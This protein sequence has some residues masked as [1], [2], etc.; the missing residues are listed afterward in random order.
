LREAP[1]APDPPEAPYIYEIKNSKARAFVGLRG[2]SIPEVARQS[3]STQ[4]LPEP[5]PS[6]ALDYAA[7]SQKL[8]T[9]HSAGDFVFEILRLANYSSKFFVVWGFLNIWKNIRPGQ[10]SKSEYTIQTRIFEGSR[11]FP[12]K[13]FRNLFGNLGIRFPFGDSEPRGPRAAKERSHRKRLLSPK[14]NDV[15]GIEKFFPILQT[16]IENFKA[17]NS[18]W[19]ASRQSNEYA[20]SLTGGYC[21]E[22]DLRGTSEVALCDNGFA[23]R[24]EPPRR[25]F[26]IL[27]TSHLARGAK[28]SKSASRPALPLASACVYPKGYLFIGPPGTGKTLLARALAGEVG[29]RLIALSASEIQKQIDVGTRI[30]AIRLRNLFQF[31]KEN[32]PCILFFDEIDSIGK[33]HDI[34]LFTE[35]LIQMDGLGPRKLSWKKFRA[36]K[37]SLTSWYCG[38]ADCSEADCGEADLWGTSSTPRFLKGNPIIPNSP[39]KQEI[40]VIG[41]TN[42]FT[43]LDSAFIRSGRFDRII[44]LQ[45]PGK[46][47]RISIL[48]L[49]CGACGKAEESPEPGSP[50]RK[51]LLEASI[52]ESDW[53]FFGDITNGLSAADLSRIVNESL[54]FLIDEEERAGLSGRGALPQDPLRSGR[55]VSTQNS[56]NQFPII[57]NYKRPSSSGGILLHTNESIKKG[58]EKILSRERFIMN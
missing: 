36:A 23:P 27:G 35:F 48:K 6:E 25:G 19:S 58:I 20:E 4:T 42:N 39:Q 43:N 31:A 14:L 34:T 15:E 37:P 13:R 2:E 8:F 55:P 52:Q 3:R 38:E 18:L 26:E 1:S 49:Y 50:E 51:A 9:T 29:V 45:Y 53:N 22:A 40:I 32:K 17:T 28:H 12:W 16:F 10:S 33:T 41:T 57:R 21:G 54:L 47:T 5:K 11:E 56:Q 46:H 7:D 24:R 30:G 44:G